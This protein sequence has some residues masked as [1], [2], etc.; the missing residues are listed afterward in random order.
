MIGQDAEKKHKPTFTETFA[1]Y[2]AVGRLYRLAEQVAT[3]GMTLLNQPASTESRDI[4]DKTQV[5]TFSY[6][7]ASEKSDLVLA[8]GNP[9]SGF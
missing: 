6:V 3:N 9:E 5:H 4:D 1:R 2:E 8:V 7:A